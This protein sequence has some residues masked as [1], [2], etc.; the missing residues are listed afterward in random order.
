MSNVQVQSP[1]NIT[2]IPKS[3]FQRQVPLGIDKH[4]LAIGLSTPK[5]NFQ[6]LIVQTGQLCALLHGLLGAAPTSTIDN[7]VCP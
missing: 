3:S 5:H 1:N 7:F 4:A 6:R 2:S